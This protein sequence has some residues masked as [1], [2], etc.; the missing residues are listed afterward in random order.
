V[1]WQEH[2]ITARL[3]GSYVIMKG[4]MPYHVPNKGEWA[5][6]HAEV[7]A[8]AAENPG[9]VAPENAPT[10]EDL[11]AQRADEIRARLT[12]LDLA[13]IRPL[14]ALADGSATDEDRL[15]IAALDAEAA[16]LREELQGLTG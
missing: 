1:D 6:L 10:P 12:E 14:R 16:A 8:F 15:R 13:S 7:A 9:Q 4:G 2:A 11:A 5:G 3:D